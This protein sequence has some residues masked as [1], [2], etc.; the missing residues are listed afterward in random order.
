[1]PMRVG[2]IYKLHPRARGIQRDSIATKRL[3][4]ISRASASNAWKWVS[5][6]TRKERVVVHTG[7]ATRSAERAIR[8][9]FN[10]GRNK[11]G[12]PSGPRYAYGQLDICSRGGRGKTDL[13]SLKNAGTVLEARTGWIK[14]ERPIRLDFWWGPPAFRSKVHI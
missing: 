13:H 8:S 9:I 11:R 10:F 7:R 6:E 5:L 14:A 2:R 4:R 12:T 3:M 1:V